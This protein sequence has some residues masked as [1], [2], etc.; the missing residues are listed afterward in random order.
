MKTLFYTLLVTILTFGSGIAAADTPLRLAGAHTDKGA[1]QADGERGGKPADK[2]KAREERDEDDDE[3]DDDK[4]KSDKDKGD[5]NKGDKEQKR[6]GSCGKGQN[7]CEPG[8]RGKKK[9]HEQGKG[10]DKGKKKGLE[11][12][13][14]NQN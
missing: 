4:E 10:M 2:G 9:G 12:G 7:D 1:Q 5:K 3:D 11:Q 6:D 14:G 8:E 13:K